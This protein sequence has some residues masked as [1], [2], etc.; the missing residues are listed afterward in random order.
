MTEKE[1]TR[2]REIKRTRWK[3]KSKVKEAVT[4]REQERKDT[5]R[6][7]KQVR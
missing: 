5:T 7:Y 4:S 1:R 3:E 6:V 2:E